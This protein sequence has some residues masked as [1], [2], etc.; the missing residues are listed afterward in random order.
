MFVCRG[1][2]ALFQAIVN[3]DLTVVG[4][5][6]LSGMYLNSR[7]KFLR[8]VTQACYVFDNHQEF[9]FLPELRS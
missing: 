1:G 4:R 8:L 6:H 7:I 9:Y 5:A 2:V 3:A